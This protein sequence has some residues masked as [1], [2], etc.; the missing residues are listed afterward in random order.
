VLVLGRMVNQVIHIGGDI[1]V[2][3]V[4][5]NDHTVHL[6]ID[7]PKEIP[8]TRPDMVNKLPKEKETE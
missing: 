2:T 1:T 3:V 5:L 4:R 6:G 8:I 7:A